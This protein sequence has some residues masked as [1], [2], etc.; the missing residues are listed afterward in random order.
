ML[1]S[2]YVVWV[3]N[4][5]SVSSSQVE[6]INADIGN[7]SEGRRRYADGRNGSR[8]IV[9]DFVSFAVRL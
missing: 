8:A 3:L 6:P 1:L 9:A 4:R 2:S 5:T 7:D